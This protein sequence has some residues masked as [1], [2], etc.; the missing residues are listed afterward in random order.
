MN[1]GYIRVSSYD[2]HTDR[3]L[4]N[5]RMDT[6][7]T[8]TVSGKDIY[9]PA[10]SACLESLREG[11]M[12]H[13]HSIDRLTRNLQ[14][15]LD[16]LSLLV[17]KGVTV[18]FHKEK[19]TF[20][21]DTCPFQKLHLQIIGA[22]AEFERAFIKDRQRE[23]IALAKSKGKY[24]GR[25]TILSQHQID[26]IMHRLS[27]QESVACLAREYGVSR[28]TIYRYVQKV[29]KV[30]AV[31]PAPSSP[32]PVSEGMGNIIIRRKKRA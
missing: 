13:V 27:T 10:L 24:K 4:E 25:K 12:L 7:Y 21:A 2:Q 5:V 6:V 14:D 16:L 30:A 20:S 29:A 17:K 8:D 22:V 19:L 9:R 18:K 11:D 23:G 26:E 28:Q 15:L 32:S 1:V 3:Q 31:P